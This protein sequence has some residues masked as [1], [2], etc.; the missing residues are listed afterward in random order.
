MERD[1]GSSVMSIYWDRMH[2][3]C[4]WRDD[5]DSSTDSTYRICFCFFLCFGG[6]IETV[7]EGHNRKDHRPEHRSGRDR[8][9][10]MGCT[11]VW[12]K[13]H[14]NGWCGE[15]RCRHVYSIYMKIIIDWLNMGGG[16]VRDRAMRLLSKTY[17]FYWCGYHNI[18]RRA[19]P[20]CVEHFHLQL[21]VCMLRGFFSIDRNKKNTHTKYINAR[22]QCMSA[23]LRWWSQR[24]WSHIQ[25]N[26][27]AINRQTSLI[28]RK[29]IRT[30]GLA[31]YIIPSPTNIPH[32]VCILFHNLIASA[33]CKCPKK[34]YILY[35]STRTDA[36][37]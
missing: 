19:K 13:G 20:I 34:R 8:E 10:G 33:E 9:F 1:S 26:F 23:S 24:W 2:L 16:R 14:W 18:Y 22:C 28:K 5:S 4:V 7:E 36:S 12:C 30:L 35:I 27:Y 17:M 31:L 3:R 11:P 25:Y 32:G 29:A 15:I 6:E 21:Y 37:F